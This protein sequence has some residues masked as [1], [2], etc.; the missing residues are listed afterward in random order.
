MIFTGK[1][2]AKIPGEAESGSRLEDTSAA[3]AVRAT[4]WQLTCSHHLYRPI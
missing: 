2:S 3:S 4:G 1:F